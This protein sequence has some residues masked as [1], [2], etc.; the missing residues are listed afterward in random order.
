M[1]HT[2]DDVKF[3]SRTWFLPKTWVYTHIAF[4]R[5][6]HK[7]PTDSLPPPFQGA[8]LLGQ[9]LVFDRPGIIEIDPIR[10]QERLPRINHAVVP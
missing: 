7:E 6:P 5:G 3:G 4:F 10:N 2:D 9:P 1:S 8:E